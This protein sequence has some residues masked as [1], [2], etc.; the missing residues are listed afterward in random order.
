[1]EKGKDVTYWNIPVPR[2][3]DQALEAAIKQNW[4]RTKSEFI[5]ELVRQEL[6]RRGFHAPGESPTTR[7]E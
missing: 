7:K 5:R 3:L 4:H 1:M 2:L 6:K